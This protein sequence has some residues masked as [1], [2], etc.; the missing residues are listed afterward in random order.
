MIAMIFMT[1]R[2]IGS[3]KTTIIKIVRAVA[4]SI[5]CFPPSYL[6]FLFS[7]ILYTYHNNK[8]LNLYSI[9]VLKCKQGEDFDHFVVFPLP[10]VLTIP[11]QKSY[12]MP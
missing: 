1:P 11:F 7:C 10:Y 3:E 9:L 4:I 2:A 12:F 6:L 5:F 8:N